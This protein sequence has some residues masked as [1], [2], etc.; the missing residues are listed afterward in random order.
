MH[1]PSIK[2]YP[3]GRQEEENQLIQFIDRY[4]TSADHVGKAIDPVDG[5]GDAK[6][7]D[8]LTGYSLALNL[9]LWFQ[10][11]LLPRLDATLCDSGAI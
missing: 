10:E 5:T 4:G 1:V 3:A 6:T 11:L 8:I 9:S 7:A 2:G